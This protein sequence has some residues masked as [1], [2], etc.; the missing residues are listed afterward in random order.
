MQKVQDQTRAVIGRSEQGEKLMME[1]CWM[2][3]W[4]AV[5]DQVEGRLDICTFG[6]VTTRVSQL[7][8]VVVVL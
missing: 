6:E 4:V 3:G 7:S 5:G 1:G 2:H 8:L